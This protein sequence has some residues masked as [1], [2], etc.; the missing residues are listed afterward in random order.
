MMYFEVTLGLSEGVSPFVCL[1]YSLRARL[2][3][4]PLPNATL[5]LLFSYKTHL[6][7]V[8]CSKS[9]AV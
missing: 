3:T 2:T 7:N 1:Y 6:P 9:S 8:S 4:Q 5:S